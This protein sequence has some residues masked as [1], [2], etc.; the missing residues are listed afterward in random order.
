MNIEDLRSKANLMN[1]LWWT[2]HG[3]KIL[4]P[5]P[6]N[7]AT[8]STAT[9][10]TTKTASSVVDASNRESVTNVTNPIDTERPTEEL[11]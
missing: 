7:S 3:D 11:D 2:Y 8:S 1:L 6:A 5:E 9:S 10:A 4:W